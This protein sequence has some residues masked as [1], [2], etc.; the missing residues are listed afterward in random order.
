MRTLFWM[1]VL[2]VLGAFFAR[3]PVKTLGAWEPRV[4]RIRLAETGTVLFYAAAVY[5]LDWN[6]PLT[7]A[8]QVAAAAGWVLTLAGLALAAW[9]RATLGRCFS[10]SLGVKQDHDLVRSG[11]YAWMR[12]PMY[13]GL[14]ALG[15]GGALVHNSGLAVALLVAPFGGF[16]YWQTRVEEPLLVARLGDAYRQYQASTGRLLPRL[17]R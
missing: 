8:S 12:H 1:V 9:S 10:V 6:F 4:I 17:M 16:F 7:K 14:L 5:L 3:R 11:P 2:G 13:T 15:L